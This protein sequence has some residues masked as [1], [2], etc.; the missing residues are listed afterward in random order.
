MKKKTIIWSTI[1]I[2][3]LACA[4]YLFLNLNAMVIRTTENIAS[5]ALGVGV[6]IGDIDLSLS[7]KKVTVSNIRINNPQGYKGKHIL[8][9]NQVSITLNT[10]SSELINFNNIQASG[11]VVNV[12][13]NEKG[14]NILDLKKL[15]SQNSKKEKKGS[16]TINVIIKKML[17]EPSTVNSRVTFLDKDIATFKL[18]PISFSNIGNNG[19]TSA[20]DVITEIITQ[21]LTKIEKQVTKKGIL[22]GVS[23]PGLNKADKIIDN[24]TD[25]LKSLF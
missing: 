23:I 2:S 7:D 18:P 17:I 11:S 12:E 5:G 16:E 24:A 13:I 10:A 3:I 6:H 4:T 9:T 1:A 25:V 21:Y 8:E 22:S 19:N 20:G 15:T 14:M